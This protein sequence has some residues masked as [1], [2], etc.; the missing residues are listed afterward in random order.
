[1]K[2]PLLQFVLLTVC[3]ASITGVGTHAL[4]MAHLHGCHGQTH[5][6]CP[7]EPGKEPQPA[8]DHAHCHFCQF[9]LGVGGKYMSPAADVFVLNEAVV[10][11]RDFYTSSFYRQPLL[12]AAV[13][14]GPPA[15]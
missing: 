2:K 5:D 1:M 11:C 15:A 8:H 12:S 13:P 7:H 6:A 14:R 10:I 4:L 9:F 3:L